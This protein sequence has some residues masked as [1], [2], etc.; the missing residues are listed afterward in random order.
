M[1]HRQTPALAF[2]HRHETEIRMTRGEKAIDVA[3]KARQMLVRQHHEWLV[4]ATEARQQIENLR[5]AVEHEMEEVPV[6]PILAHHAEIV[7]GG[8]VDPHKG[9]GKTQR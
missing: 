2:R 9:D 3:L 4:A 5:Q 6:A 7:R 1:E 8:V